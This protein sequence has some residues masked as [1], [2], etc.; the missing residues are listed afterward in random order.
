[1]S[2]WNL[3]LLKFRLFEIFSTKLCLRRKWWERQ[4]WLEI[5]IYRTA[6]SKIYTHRA[7][8]S[9]DFDTTDNKT[10]LYNT[11]TQLEK[12]DK[13]I[14]EHFNTWN[15]VIKLKIGFWHHGV[16]ECLAGISFCL[17]RNVDDSHFNFAFCSLIFF[18]TMKFLDDRSNDR[19]TNR[20]WYCCVWTNA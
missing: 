15:C 4:K 13:S 12:A 20:W 14:S 1:M 16:L 7:A 5:L 9:R 3:I 11:R 10:I 2:G 17:R 18:E 8:P 19:W 6:N